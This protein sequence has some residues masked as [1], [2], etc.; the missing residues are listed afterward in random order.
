[1]SIVQLLT[2]LNASS[3]SI[4]R[5]NIKINS[6]TVNFPRAQRLNVRCFPVERMVEEKDRPTSSGIRTPAA[7]GFRRSPSWALEMAYLYLKHPSLTCAILSP[8]ATERAIQQW[9]PCSGLVTIMPS[10]W[11]MFEVEVRHL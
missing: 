10:Q 9:T 8:W 3:S 1:M 7:F 2:R 4:L 11:R 6:T 5:N